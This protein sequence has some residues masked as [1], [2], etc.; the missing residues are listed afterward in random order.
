MRKILILFPSTHDALRAEKYWP[1]TGFPGKL[2]PIPR[3]LSS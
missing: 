2:R 1:R 3:V